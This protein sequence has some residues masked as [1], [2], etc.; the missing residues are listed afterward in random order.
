[1]NDL[2]GFIPPSKDEWDNLNLAPMEDLSV[3]ESY[4]WL[5]DRYCWRQYESVGRFIFT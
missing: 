5:R 2:I 4:V 3:V 1:M